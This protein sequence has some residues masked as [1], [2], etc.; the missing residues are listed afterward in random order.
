MPVGLLDSQFRTLEEPGPDER[1][2]VV[3]ID[4]TP[5]EIVEEIIRKL[6]VA[7]QAPA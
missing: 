4:G 7:P 6:G 3:D 5:A 1:P 2:I